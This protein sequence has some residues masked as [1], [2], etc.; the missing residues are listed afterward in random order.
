MWNCQHLVPISELFANQENDA[1]GADRELPNSGSAHAASPGSSH[2]VPDVQEK[3]KDPLLDNQEAMGQID[4]RSS[5]SDD[6]GNV[7][8]KD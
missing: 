1:D 3:T 7:D 5:S 4:S 6:E 2:S 8:I